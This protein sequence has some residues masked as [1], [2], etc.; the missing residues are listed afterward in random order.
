MGHKPLALDKD[1]GLVLSTF[2]IKEK[3]DVST[4]NIHTI[5][6]NKPG[7]INSDTEFKHINLI[8]E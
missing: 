4:T 8:F 1:C 3:C 6:Q 5:G 7:Q 2:I